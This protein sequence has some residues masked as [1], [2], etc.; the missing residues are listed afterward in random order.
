MTTLAHVL[1]VISAILLLAWVLHFHGRL[2]L[3]SDNPEHI[4]NVHPIV[5]YFGFI[6]VMGEGIMVYKMIPLQRRVRKMV[7]M[8][9]NFV[10][11]CFGIF[12]VYAAFKYHKES[13]I[14]DM[15]SLHSWLGIITICLYGLQWVVGFLGFWIRVAPGYMRERMVPWHRSMGL[16]LFLMAVCTAETGLVE[17]ATL[18]QLGPGVES[19]LMNFAGLAIL[20]FGMAVAFSVLL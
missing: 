8:M 7:H 14:T 5:M 15:Y 11:L 20:L 16:F 17:K 12:G 10:A 13:S 19:C 6:F 2:W 18:S 1:G 9:F 3:H 4:F